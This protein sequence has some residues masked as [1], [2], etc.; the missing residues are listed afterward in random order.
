DPRVQQ[1]LDLKVPIYLFE[2]K[3]ALLMPRQ[4]PSVASLSRFPEVRRDIAIIIDRK[5][6]AGEVRACIQGAADETLQ[7]LKLFDVYQ[8]KGIDPNG[9]S[10]AL[11]LTFQHPS[12]T[13]TDDEINR[14]VDRIV[15]SLEKQLHAKLRN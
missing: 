4:V 3:T 11:G 15:A 8:G 10:L 2:L 9:K 13:L 12:R 7:N 1:A 5:I 6:T 14:S